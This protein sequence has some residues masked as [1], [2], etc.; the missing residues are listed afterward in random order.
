MI[1]A[2]V[3]EREGKKRR[4]AWEST[5]TEVDLFSFFLSFLLSFFQPAEVE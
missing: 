1:A 4:L 3:K 2:H 5:S